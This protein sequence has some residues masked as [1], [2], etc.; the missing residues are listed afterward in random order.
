MDS[1]RLCNCT[2]RK[3][4]IYFGISCHFQCDPPVLITDD[5]LATHLYHIAQEA[6]TN[7]VKHARARNILIRLFE[8]DGRGTLLVRDDGN[9]LVQPPRDHAGMGLQ[10]MRHRADMIGGTL[11]VRSEAMQGT[12]VTCRF[13]LSGNK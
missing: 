8:A 10:I 13:P 1:C 2:R 5:T 9:G 12:I 3:S 6:V 7:A 11:E 4:R